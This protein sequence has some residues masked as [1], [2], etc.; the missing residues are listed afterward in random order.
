VVVSGTVLTIWA[1]EEIGK[2]TNP[3]SI[4]CELDETSLYEGYFSAEPRTIGTFSLKFAPPK[5]A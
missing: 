4:M 5:S 2:T 3:A 1:G